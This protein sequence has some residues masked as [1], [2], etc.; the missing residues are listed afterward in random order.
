MCMIVTAGVARVRTQAEPRAP[1]VR[2]QLEKE[3]D[4]DE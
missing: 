3:A 2:G 4:R 1:G